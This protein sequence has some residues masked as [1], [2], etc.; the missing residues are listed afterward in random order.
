[1]KL[2]QKFTPTQLSVTPWAVY[3]RCSNHIGK[4]LDNKFDKPHLSVY[5]HTRHTSAEVFDHP[6]IP[7]ADHLPSS[8]FGK[9]L[10]EEEQE[11]L[12]ALQADESGRRL[13]VVGD[14]GTGKTT[15]LKHVIDIH[16]GQ[17][18]FS[19][20]LA[21]YMDWSDFTASVNDPVPAIHSRFVGKVLEALEKSYG[22]ARLHAFDDDIFLKATM[23][24]ADRSMALRYE[25]GART[26]RVIAA[27]EN[28]LKTC[29]VDLTFERINA[30]CQSDKDAIVLI[31]DN[32]DHLHS[33]VLEHLFDFLTEIQLRAIPMLIVAMRDHTFERGNSAYRR[34]RAVPAWNLRLKPP[35]IKLMLERRIQHFLPSTIGSAANEVL[36][37][38]AGVLYADRKLSAVCRALLN[39]PFSNVETYE[40]LCNYSNFNIRDLFVT[41]QEILGCPG[42]AAYEGDLFKSQDPVVSIGIDQCLIA[43]GLKN[44]LMFFPDKSPLFNPY[45]AGA[46]SNILDKVVAVR[47][48]QL[49]N[50]RTSPI[51]LGDLETRFVAWGY[52]K[53]AFDAQVVSMVNKDL[54]WTSTGAPTDFGKES[55]LRLSYRGRLYAK[56]LLRRSIFN[57]MMSFD[58]EA[59]SES[60]P[61]YRHHRKDFDSELKRVA[62]FGSQL[63][64]EAIAD[65]VLG[66]ASII[67]DAERTELQD[68]TTTGKLANFKA[69]V[70]PTS[71]S[72]EIVEGLL[73]FLR[74]G[75]EADGTGSQLTAP[76][77]AT[78]KSVSDTKESYQA[79]FKYVW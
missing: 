64:S 66:L 71:I 59:P 35:N 67:F 52:N 14:V 18:A 20:G 49:L 10:A 27:F 62:Q 56:T 24:A 2:T 29:P 65:R 63:E 72:L 78:L 1:M 13:N 4:I 22:P 50:N 55:R 46:D 15:F 37:V 45:S 47:V 12:D 77:S 5:E 7:N 70:A 36:K 17:S 57:Y 39:A 26:A 11:L 61:I 60:H 53:R 44:H 6:P 43:L 68:L 58:V 76:S 21:I 9:G 41:L 19:L 34:D 32:I 74:R 3:S 23:F 42:F 79:A 28:A 33:S 54:L 8:Q 25:G 31:V 51:A 48:I 75:H 69:D 73:R 30:L 40:F 16:F 38:G